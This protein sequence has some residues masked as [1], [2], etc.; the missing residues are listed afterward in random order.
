MQWLSRVWVKNLYDMEQTS[1]HVFEAEQ[2]H[3]Y[4]VRMRWYKTLTHVVSWSG[5][6]CKKNVIEKAKC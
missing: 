6:R 4:Q 5:N 1:N 2:K 3:V